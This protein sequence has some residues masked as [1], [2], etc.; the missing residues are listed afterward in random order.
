MD[1]EGNPAAMEEL[2]AL[3]VPRV[4]AVVLEGRVV[5]GWQPAAYA[6]LVG[7]EWDGGAM[8]EPDELRL[9]LDRILALAQEALRQA[10]GADFA[11]TP[12]GRGRSLHDLSYHIFR[13]AA[14]FVDCLEQG[15]FSEDWFGE[16]APPE[17]A[18]PAEIA[19]HGDRVRA[20]LAA[21]FAVAPTEIYD[22]DAK[23]YYGDQRVH[24][25]LERTTW[26]CAQHTRQIYHLLE[27]QNALPHASLD[28]TALA[29]LPIPA[30]MW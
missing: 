13:V 10:G 26:H 18:S 2:R 22:T 12:P 27:E 23:T 15:W 5:H 25:L 30:E 20:R 8:L 19:D 21:W 7:V 3:G 16:P 14:A 11:V 1:V 17:L 28:T 4:P 29:G 24:D 9:R 6:E